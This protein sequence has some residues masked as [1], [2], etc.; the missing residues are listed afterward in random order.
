MNKTPSGYNPFRTH[1]VQ[2]KSLL[3]RVATAAIGLPTLAVLVYIGGI[4]FSILV[5]LAAS[6]GAFELYKMARNNSLS[7][8]LLVM[9]IW[10]LA[11]VV[12]THILSGDF[13][14]DQSFKTYVVIAAI[15]Y[16]V[17]QLHRSRSKVSWTN[18]G[19]ATFTALYTGGLLS[20]AILLRDIAQG[21]EWVYLAVLVAFATDTCAFFIGSTIG[22]KPLA[23]SISPGKTWEGSVAG[24][25]GGIIAC[26]VI[27]FSFGLNLSWS[28][29][30]ALGA[31]VAIAT[32]LGDLFESRIKRL[33]NVKNSG[34]LLPGHG[35][36][37]DRLDSIVPSLL[38][39]YYAV[40]WI[41]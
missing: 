14:E 38:V 18:W 23:P 35:G 12:V 7:P 9:L 31:I 27:S 16:L 11:P 2:V 10:S 19:I 34:R 33:A 39:V 29:A 25:V 5:A 24:L 13:S 22:R 40:L 30:I 20:H 28:Q 32:Q 17:W 15:V 21:R 3:P 36:I 41:M 1:T 26:L 4:W 8:P 37:L 6:I